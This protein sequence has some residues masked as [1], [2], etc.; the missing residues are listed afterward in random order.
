MG[1]CDDARAAGLNQVNE[2]YN[3]WLKEVVTIIDNM[4]S[5]GLDPTKYYDAKN[6][7]VINLVALLSD[8]GVAREN[9]IREVN[10]T[11]DSDCDGAMNFGQGLIDMTVAS[12]T[13]GLSLIL[14]KH[15]THIDFEEIASGY[16]LGGPGSAFNQLR[17]AI[18]NALGMGENNDL[19]KVLVNPIS[20]TKDKV[21]D[22]LKGLN[23][24]FRL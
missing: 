15:M 18:F 1:V 8:L 3:P 14:P 9:Q 4:K 23:L 13:G 5:K 16:P 22:L 2:F 7:E 21:N 24:P 11:V 6:N 10:D 12:F 17:E 19:R 20:E